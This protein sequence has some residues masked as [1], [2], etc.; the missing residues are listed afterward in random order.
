MGERF[1]VGVDLGGTN[2]RAAVVDGEGKIYGRAKL[3]TEA[4]LGKTAVIERMAKT[5]EGAIKDAGIERNKIVA[6]GVGAPG[7]LNSKTGVIIEAPNLPGWKEVP[8]KDE[9]EGHLGIE[10]FVE[11]DANSAA[12]GE[13]WC[14]AG[15]DVDTL[16]CFTLG[17]GVGGGLVIGGQLWRGIDD[18]AAEI[19]HMTI[20]P[21]GPKCGCGNYGCLEALASATATARRAR[22]AIEAGEKSLLADM[23][24]GDLSKI[25]AAMV[26][27]AILKGDTLAE[28]IM[29]QTGVY[30]GIAIASLVN[31]LNPEMVVIGGGMSAAGDYLFKPIR[32]EVDGKRKY[33]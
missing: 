22:E 27:E 19:G 10:T 28:Q 2:L 16:I 26:Y 24:G 11:N 8:L 7:P 30:L 20:L 4:H 23:C 12:W 6:V 9:L 14:G 29:R 5:V 18:T 31:V 33:P 17:T 3:S 13:K 15:K 1:V 25:T 32:E 21:D